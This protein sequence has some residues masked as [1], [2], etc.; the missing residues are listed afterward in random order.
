MEQFRE[1]PQVINSFLNYLI[2]HEVCPE[3]MEDMERA[4]KIIE[5]AKEELPKCKSLAQ[6]APG[7]FNKACSLIY[8]GELCGLFDDPWDGE[9]N[10]AKLIGISL[11]EGKGI[12]EKVFGEGALKLSR[13]KLLTALEVE[14]LEIE[15][16]RENTTKTVDESATVKNIS[17]SQNGQTQ[18]D[19]NVTE[20]TSTKDVN[21]SENGQT[22]HDV[23]ATTESTNTN[24][25]S[26]SESGRTTR[27]DINIT[28][29]EDASVPENGQVQPNDFTTVST[30]T[31]DV[32]TSEGAQTQMDTSV[33]DVGISEDGK[34][35]HNV[36]DATKSTDVKDKSISKTGI[37]Q[38]NI[39]EVTS[40]RKMIVR[41]FR[42]LEI[43][44]F[45]IHLGPDVANCPMPGML[46]TADFH[47]LSNGC[48]YWDRVT[49]V[50]PS[51]YLAVD[52]DDED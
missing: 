52:S 3:Y 22:Q 25:V 1:A 47:C 40:L 24:D 51:Y 37:T 16:I 31:K 10:V 43:E 29:T 28:N 44:P 30:D 48:W 17:I 39:D 18:L 38:I 49:N 7:K 11:S 34:T 4:L 45:A 32:S 12:V 13:E 42:N 26:I 20:S 2:A 15:S 23:K 50:Y 8:G 41:P 46:I 19:E 36:N 6:L 35:Q 5:R 21:I 9:E 14:V 27:L 33:E